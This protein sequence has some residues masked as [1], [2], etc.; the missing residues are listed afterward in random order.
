MRKITDKNSESS[1]RSEFIHASLFAEMVCARICLLA[2]LIA[3]NGVTMT[4]ANAVSIAASVVKFEVRIAAA[5]CSIS[6]RNSST[7]TRYPVGHRSPYDS[8]LS[9]ES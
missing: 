2:I 1:S 9:R 6:G 8:E 7:F 3:T 5:I 4:A